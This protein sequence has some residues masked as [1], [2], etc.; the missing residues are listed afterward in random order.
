MKVC[1]YAIAKNEEKFVDRW[2]R[3]MSEA[4]EIYVLDTGSTDNTIKLLKDRGVNVRN[5]TYKNFRFDRA[6]NDSMEMLPEDADICVCTDLDEV[7]TKGWRE[8]LEKAWIRGTKQAKYRYVWNYNADGSEGYVFMY[9]KIHARHG[10][11]WTHPVHEVLK[12]DTKSFEVVTVDGVTLEH[13]ADPTKSRGQY[14]GLLE[15]S[16]KEDPND[17]RNMHYLGREYMF[18]GEWQKAINTLKKH[19]LLPTS[20]WKDERCASMRFI[21]RCHVALGQL[22]EAEFYFK[23]AICEC[24]NKREAFWEL[25]KFYYDKEKWLE[26]AAAI[27]SM[28]NIT[29]RDLSYISDP[30]C[31]GGMPYDL[32]S[33]CDYYL[34]NKQEATRNAKIALSFSPNDTRL[35]GNLKI[36]ESM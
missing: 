22:G 20:L 7:F 14:L 35:L 19:L 5:K 23:L 17:D 11:V 33:I 34:S 15:Q 12:S 28:F 26:C 30:E 32:L 4:D 16:V 3:S 13:H 9:E 24:P 29:K 27:Y 31:W 18:A 10:F 6:R 21:G 2:V 36:F 1:V 25:G 8:K